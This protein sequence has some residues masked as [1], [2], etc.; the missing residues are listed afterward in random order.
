[1]KKVV[2][3]LTIMVFA[4]GSMLI[5]EM[6]AEE[7]VNKHIE[8][9]GG[10]EAYAN[11]E[12]IV[13]KGNM[14]AQ[15]MPLDFTSYL[16][17]PDKAYM[18]ASTNNMVV[19]SGG[20]DGK[21]AWAKSAM[22]GAVIL[23]GAEKESAMD[24]TELSRFVDYKDKGFTI[25]YVGEDMVKGAKTYK[26]ELVDPADNDTTVYYFD[27]ETY[28]ILRE[29][30]GGNTITYSKH[31]KVGDKIVRP[32]K[33]NISGPGAQGQRM[34]TFE[35]ME[36]NVDVPDSLFVM[37]EGAIPMSEMQKRMQQQQMPGGGQ[38]GGGQQGGG[39]N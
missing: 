20:T 5:A 2:I 34:I 11:L 13:M 14:F 23:E 27:A 18:E 12:S 4:A 7:I 25:R 17:M 16:V 15:G 24:Q 30:S 35:S 1:M 9:I 10:E 6:T 32:F 22:V 8:A 37:P 33:V 21:E 29:K 19:F 36:V 28:Y 39:G 26:V 38:Q 31:Q 3:L